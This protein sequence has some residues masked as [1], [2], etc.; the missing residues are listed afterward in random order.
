MRS[1]SHIAVLAGLL[2]PSLAIAQQQPSGAPQHRLPPYTGAQNRRLAKVGW[3]SHCSS[4]RR[5]RVSYAPNSGYS[6][7]LRQVKWWATSG[8]MHRNKQCARL[9][10]IWAAAW[11]CCG[12]HKRPTIARR[13]IS[14]F[15]QALE[16]GAELSRRR[17]GMMSD[18]RSPSRLPNLH[19]RDAIATPPACSHSRIAGASC[20]GQRC[21]NCE[22]FI[23]AP[24]IGAR[25]QK[26]VVSI[27]RKYARPDRATLRAGPC[28]MRAEIRS[29][30]E[31]ENHEDDF[32]Y[33]GVFGRVAG[34]CLAAGA[35]RCGAEGLWRLRS[36]GMVVRATEL[37][38]LRSSG[39][40][41]LRRLSP[42]IRLL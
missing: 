37:R 39:P 5:R 13:A 8:L 3:R 10:R 27:L 42:S 14:P 16:L 31:E 40:A 1:L 22:A 7:A 9:A 12:W 17:R 28:R 34:C 19:R 2:L 11:C 24:F 36:S 23:Q 4:G 26:H 25:L 29:K 38:R 18:A 15:K 32:R 6:A 35:T 20:C 41:V 30:I 21:Q 33:S